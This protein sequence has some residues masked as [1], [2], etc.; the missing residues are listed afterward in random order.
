LIS[1]R[2]QSGVFARDGE[3]KFQ[4]QAVHNWPSDVIADKPAEPE[5]QHALDRG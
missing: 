5:A 2:V 4:L 3:E 1:H